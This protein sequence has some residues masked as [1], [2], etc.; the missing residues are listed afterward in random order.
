MHWSMHWRTSWTSSR[1]AARALGRLADPQAAQPL[2][3]RLARGSPDLILE[4]VGLLARSGEPRF[5]LKALAHCLRGS[6]LVPF[7]GPDLPPALTGFLDRAN[8]AAELARRSGL[9]ETDLL[10]LAAARSLQGNSRFIF[11]DFLKR[12]LV[13][14]IDRPGSFF[15][16]LAH[17]DIRFWVSGAWD[18]SLAQALSAYQ[19]VMGEDTLYVQNERPVVV[20]LVGDLARL[21]GVVILEDDYRQL[22]EDETDRRLLVDFLRRNLSGKILLFLGYNPNSPDFSLLVKYILN[23]HLAGLKASVFQIWPEEG[24]QH[25]WNDQPMRQ[26]D[27]GTLEAI[28]ELVRLSG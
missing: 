2:L 19:V 18:G 25:I 13:D 22:R 6:Q 15:L 7:L 5:S 4:L 26:I 9:M 21:R 16:N 14:P 11:T 23:Q 8:L 10:A 17:L 1:S 28:R 24:Q 3:D 12:A 20:Q 27:P